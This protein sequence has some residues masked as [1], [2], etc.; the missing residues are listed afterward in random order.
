MPLVVEP[1]WQGRRVS[2]RRVVERNE[3]GSLR[4]G[5]VVGELVGLDAQTA[6]VETRTGP[7]EVPRALIAAARLV[8][9]STADELGLDRIAAA[10]LRAAETAELDGWVLRADHG[11]LRRANSV[12]PAGQLRRPLG[13]ALDAAREWYAAR[14]L[15]LLISVPVE[16]RR[17]LDAE[18]GERG[19]DFAAESHVMTARLDHVSAAGAP[20][21]VA[22]DLLAEPDD[23][24][25]ALYRRG[26]LASGT[27]R[28]LLTRHDDVVFAR[29]RLD[30]RTVATARGTVD[31][32][33]LGL[34]AVEV[35]P[36]YRRRG[37]ARAVTAAAWQWGRERGAVRSYLQVERD[38]DAAVGLYENLGYRVH[39]DYLYRED[40]QAHP[41]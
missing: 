30:G 41:V 19:W 12:L 38:N 36:D 32:G 11:L 7:V 31:E 24:W 26:E 25:L 35:D 39:H 29:V 3:D 16:A 34:I 22:V 27:G 8:P 2:V 13:E 28:A 6:V 33:W 15:P 9:P 4:F 10:G 1:S 23:E 37:L 17:L 40:P 14:G 5:D 18:L 20:D 21:D